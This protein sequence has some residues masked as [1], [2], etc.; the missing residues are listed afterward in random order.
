MN[1]KT[2]LRI[3]CKFWVIRKHSLISSSFSSH[4]FPFRAV[5]AA[6]GSSWERGRTGTVAAGLQSQ[7]QQHQI[8]AASATYD[9]CC[10]LQQQWILNPLSQARDWICT[11][12]DDSQVG[13]EPT[14]P[15]L[16]LPVFL[17]SSLKIVPLYVTGTFLDLMSYSDNKDNHR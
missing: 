15:Q 12:M 6:Y 14:E 11:L 16:E 4:F 1:S 13:S 17:N 3:T 9:W 7:P 10:S 5:S 8:W 2:A